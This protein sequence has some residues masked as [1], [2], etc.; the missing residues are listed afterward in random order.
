M[1]YKKILLALDFAADNNAIIDKAKTAVAQNNAELLLVHVNQTLSAAYS[2]GPM[3]GWDQQIAEI[4]T[5]ARR[6]ADEQMQTLGKELGVAE[7]NRLIREGRPAA[8]IRRVAEDRGVDLIV[9]GTHGQHGL[10]LL[11]G[12]T[13]NGVLHGVSCDVMVVRVP[14]H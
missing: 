9:I 11:L 12:S 2:A 5:A 8:E 3:G 14:D 10:E 7:E 4:E 13:A 6:H 1:A